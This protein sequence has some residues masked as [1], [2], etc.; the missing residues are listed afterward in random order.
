MAWLGSAHEGALALSA[1]ND[2][3]VPV[4]ATCGKEYWIVDPDAK[5]ITVLLR[6][7]SRFKDSGIY[8]EEQSLSSTFARIQIALDQ[9]I[10]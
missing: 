5:T 3:A 4:R 8:V 6:A 10:F 7:E 2:Q 1:T 9:E